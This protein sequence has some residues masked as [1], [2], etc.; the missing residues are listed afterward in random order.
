[1]ADLKSFLITLKIWV[2]IASQIMISMVIRGEIMLIVCKLHNI[3]CVELVWG[4]ICSFNMKNFKTVQKSF[5]NLDSSTCNADL[6]H[7]LHAYKMDMKMYVQVDM[8]S[9]EKVEKNSSEKSPFSAMG[10]VFFLMPL[11]L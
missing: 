3:N 10:T 6:K 7:R 8:N 1:M 4:H 2:Q 11:Q 9:K 5:W